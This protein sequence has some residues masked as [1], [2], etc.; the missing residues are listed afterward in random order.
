MG[1][2]KN[3]EM[4]E[5]NRS[6]YNL[7]LPKTDSYT[8]EETLASYT[9]TLLKLT[10]SAVPDDAFLALF[11]GV[12][13]YLYRVK[14]QLSDGTPVSGS[15]I[16]GLSAVTG[17][18][19]TTGDDGIVLGKST[20][21]SVTINCTSP[22]IDQKPPAAQTFTKTGTITD[23]TLILENDTSLMLSRA[24]KIYKFSP[25]VKTVDLCATGGGGGGCLSSGG[26][27]G[28]TENL[29]NVNLFSHSLLKFVIGSG[30]GAAP[31]TTE[32]GKDGGATAVYLDNEIILQALGGKGGIYGTNGGSGGAGNGK[33]GNA[34]NYGP[35]GGDATV[36]I[37][38]DTTIGIKTGGGGGG[39]GGLINSSVTPT[40]ESEIGYRGLPN[41]G[42]GAYRFLTINHDTNIP[43][44]SGADGGGGGGG[45][46]YDFPAAGGG[47]AGI[48][49]FRFHFTT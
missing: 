25:V 40:V 13:S 30:G 16:S 32:N 3:I 34:A 14:V 35:R 33:G 48:I 22:Y 41:G 44:E 15:T 49:Y 31:A 23:V 8:K 28:Y 29:M 27:G 37:F 45:R 17:Q 26:G 7:L 12:D 38:N 24:S 10:N 6:D 11:L 18:T 19:L 5:Y 42:K 1:A 20:S 43:A 46:N 4:R 2:V 21:E 36:P 39:G 47:G 9:K